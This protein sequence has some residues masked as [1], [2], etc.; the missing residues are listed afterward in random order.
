MRIAVTGATGHLGRLVIDALLERGAPAGQV[1]AV[2]RDTGRAGDLAARGVQV[3]H[4]DYDQPDTLATALA[5]TD[6][7]L[8]VSG[9]ELGQRVEQHRAVV[10]AAAA[11]GVR[12]LAYTSIPKADTTPLLLAAEHRA[13]EEL[14]RASGLPFAFLRNSFYLEVYTGQLPTYLEHGAIVGAA[15]DGRVSAATR[16][17]YAA[18]AAAVLTGDGHDGAVYELGGDDAFTMTELAAAVSAR[19]GRDIP[20]RDLPFEEYTRVLTGAGLP[21]PLAAV[22]A[23]SDAG[24]ARGDL[25]VTTGELS[26]LIGRPTTP[27]T[28]ALAAP[29]ADLLP[30]PTGSSDT[31]PA[32]FRIFHRHCM[33]HHGPPGG[34]DAQRDAPSRLSTPIRRL[35]GSS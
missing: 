35:Y 31:G 5:G 27:Y 7:V 24:V 1:V 6:K 32:G 2:V 33:G 11:A 28:D 29:A 26:R 16:A 14:I 34:R 22:V 19:T 23:D 20:Y 30:G 18:A 9:S 3:R 15:G 25:L 10:E 21:E 8:L 13:T 4:G 12:L 17:D